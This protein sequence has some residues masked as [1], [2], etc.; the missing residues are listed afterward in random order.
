MAMDRG[1]EAP[2]RPCVG[3]GVTTPAAMDRG[4]EAPARPCVGEGGGS[5]ICSLHVWTGEEQGALG[6]GEWTS[7]ERV[8]AALDWRGEV[9]G[10]L[11]EQRHWLGRVE[12]SLASVEG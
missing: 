7:E 6:V 5:T 12:A 4:G 1:G 3:E 10:R 2:T 9:C 8:A 11:E